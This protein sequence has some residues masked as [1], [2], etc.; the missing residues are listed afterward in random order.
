M[1]VINQAWAVAPVH[2][3]FYDAMKIYNLDKNKRSFVGLLV[4]RRYLVEGLVVLALL[5]LATLTE[6]IQYH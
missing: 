6:P 5:I 1:L 4:D 2:G 3:Y